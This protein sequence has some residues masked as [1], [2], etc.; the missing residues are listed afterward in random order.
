MDCMGS[1]QF[2][3]IGNMH[4][5]DSFQDGS[6]VEEASNSDDILYYMENNK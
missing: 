2:I 4:I 6:L 5:L 3:T 1:I